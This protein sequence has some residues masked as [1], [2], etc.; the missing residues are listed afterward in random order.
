MLLCHGGALDELCDNV[1]ALTRS[2]ALGEAWTA[3]R[4]RPFNPRDDVALEQR[5]VQ[6]AMD[7]GQC[8]RLVVTGPERAE[9][10]WIFV[11]RRGNLRRALAH[12][13]E[14]IAREDEE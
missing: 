8:V 12:V 6:A 9:H 1:D 11:L 7:S 5:C 3:L 4:G 2:S 14:D 10:G 13:A